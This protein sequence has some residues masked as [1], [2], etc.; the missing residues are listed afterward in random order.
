MLALTPLY[1]PISRFFYLFPSR[2]SRPSPRPRLRPRP[3]SP[4]FSS[5]FRGTLLYF[6][7]FVVFYSF[8]TFIVFCL[9]GIISPFISACSY[10]LFSIFPLLSPFPPPSLSPS[11]V[12]CGSEEVLLVL[13]ASWE[14]QRDD[15]KKKKNGNKWV[16]VIQSGKYMSSFRREQRR[17]LVCL[18]IPMCVPEVVGS[19]A[20][21]VLSMMWLFTRLSK[22]FIDKRVMFCVCMV[23]AVAGGTD[24]K[25]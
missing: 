6:A 4:L 19:Q 1:F 9:R 5:S 7:Q 15:E 16:C 2:R 20:G 11:S 17:K 14:P 13:V 21:F 25:L 12:L 10:S 23:I 22:L 24:G 8:L 18:L 3:P